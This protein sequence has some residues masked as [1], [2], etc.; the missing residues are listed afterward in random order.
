MLTADTSGISDANGIENATF[1]YQWITSDGDMDT[2]ISGA[3]GSTYTVASADE[4]N[5]IKVRVT[6]TDDDGFSESLTSAG[7]DIPVVPLEGFFDASTVPSGHDGATTFTFQLYFNLEPKL[8]FEK[9]RDD[10][11]TITNGEV[12]AVRRTHPQSSTPNS[13]WE[14]TVQPSGN[15]AV[16][17]ALSPTTDCTADSAVCT[18]Y[19]KKLSNSAS[20][21]VAGP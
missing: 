12:T 7:L 16:T 8:G 18:R 10:V 5:A 2:P 9:V 11:L 21:T 17:I 13:R 15:G 6:F 4:G 1:A 20:L 19:G 14:I 3:T